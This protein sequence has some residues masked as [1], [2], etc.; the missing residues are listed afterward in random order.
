MHIRYTADDE[1]V[2]KLVAWIAT[3]TKETA[4]GPMWSELAQHMRWSMRKTGVA[5]RQLHRLGLVTYTT[6]HRSLRSVPGATKGV[7]H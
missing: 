4:E 7:E 6:E 5:L 2:K 3:Y 1:V